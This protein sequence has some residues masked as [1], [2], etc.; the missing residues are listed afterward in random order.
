MDL[1]QTRNRNGEMLTSKTQTKEDIDKRDTREPFLGP[2]EVYE[3]TVSITKSL[4]PTP[5]GAQAQR[6][7]SDR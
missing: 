2:Q 6:I 3:G 5:T 4:I 1:T 7:K